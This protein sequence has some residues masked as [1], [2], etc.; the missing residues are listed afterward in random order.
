[1]CYLMPRGVAVLW[2]GL[3]L[4]WSWSFTVCQPGLGIA[5]RL[6]LGGLGNEQAGSRRIRRCR[7]KEES[8]KKAFGE[9][10]GRREGKDCEASEYHSTAQCIGQV[11][12]DT[13]TG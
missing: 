6:R 3:A 5:P 13:N 10:K 1:M 8:E 9:K 11:V 4:G 2:A 12:M 7:K